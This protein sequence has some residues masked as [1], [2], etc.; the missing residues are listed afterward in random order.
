MTTPRRLH[1]TPSTAYP[2][3]PPPAQSAQAGDDNTPP[4]LLDH[5]AIAHSGLIPSADV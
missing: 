3:R 1:C 5:E 2:Y 4:D